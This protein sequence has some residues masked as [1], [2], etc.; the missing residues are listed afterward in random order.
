MKNIFY[1]NTQIELNI[2]HFFRPSPSCLIP[3]MFEYFFCR[4]L[5]LCVLLAAHK[6][7]LKRNAQINPFFEDDAS[8]ACVCDAIVGCVCVYTSECT[9]VVTVVVIAIM[10]MNVLPI[11]QPFFFLFHSFLFPCLPFSHP[12]LLHS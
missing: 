7:K 1:I 6:T 11:T 3:E 2:Q 5:P 10:T 12:L 4:H 9:R 8:C